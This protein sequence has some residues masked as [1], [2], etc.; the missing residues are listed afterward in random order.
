MNPA[1]QPWPGGTPPS[2][3]I[4]ELPQL[5][6]AIETIARKMREGNGVE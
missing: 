5:P 4:R 2:Q 1:G 3:E 6:A